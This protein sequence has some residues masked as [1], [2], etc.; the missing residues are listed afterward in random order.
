MGSRP[1]KIA[2]KSLQPVKVMGKELP[3]R[4]AKLTMGNPFDIYDWGAQD[5][6]AQEEGDEQ[7][8]EALGQKLPVL[9]LIEREVDAYG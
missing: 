7:P 1:G 9:P 2:P 6:D 8:L 3:Q 4:T 5:K